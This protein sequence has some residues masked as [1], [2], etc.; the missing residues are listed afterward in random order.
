MTNP[1]VQLD[2]LGQSIW[3]DDIRRSM[4][5]SGQLRKMIEQDGLRGM[6][7]NPSIFEKAIVGSHDYDK[8]IQLL[9]KTGKNATEIYEALTEQD[10]RDAADCF[11]V[12]YDK[13]E[14]RDGYVSL[15]VN[16]HLAHDTEGTI[17]EAQRLWKRVNRPNIFIK[18]PGTIEGLPA[19]T[20]LI[21][22]GIN[23]NVTL[24]FGLKRYRAVTEAF[25]EGLQARLADGHTLDK[26]SSV[27]SFFLSRIDVLLDPLFDGMI[28]HG[29]ER[30]ETAKKLKGQVAIASAKIAY[31]I[32]KD[33]F[34]P[35]LFGSLAEQG[36]RPQRVLWASTG[37]KNPA[38]S[39]IKYVESL[40]GPGTINTVPLETLNAYKDHGKPKLTLEE[41]V[42]NAEWVYGQLPR[43]GIDMEK[44]AHQLEDEGV[45]KFITPF[46][47]LMA[48]INTAIERRGG[49][50]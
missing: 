38:Y 2:V 21:R 16:P 14:G 41:D 49:T 45:Q 39:D 24:L 44:V 18:V 23:V 42:D 4:I 40:I 34:S 33:I 9:V 7:S 20:Q 28:A 37:T 6:T 43:L 13:S 27:A 1:C 15:E 5:T 46:D 10:V 32:Y 25:M 50:P 30:G 47:Q 35:E 48:T 3:L 12:V 11:R 31:Q 26:L 17:A 19:I 8:A 36:A 29:R 22:E